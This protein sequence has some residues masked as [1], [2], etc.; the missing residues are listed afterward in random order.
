MEARWEL[1][2]RDAAGTVLA[3]QAELEAHGIPTYVPEFGCDPFLAASSA[4]V[5]GLY[6]PSDALAL[7]RDVIAEREAQGE[8]ALR[9]SRG[10]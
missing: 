10:L 5:W 4:F 6:V 1:V 7:A 3:R 8:A 9:S 2:L